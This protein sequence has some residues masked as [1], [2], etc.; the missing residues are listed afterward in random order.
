V[1]YEKV[2]YLCS[3]SGRRCRGMRGSADL[4]DSDRL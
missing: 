1:D 4:T 3:R 2:N